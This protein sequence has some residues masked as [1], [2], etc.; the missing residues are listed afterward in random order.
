[1]GDAQPVPSEERLGQLS[2]LI[3]LI[4]RAHALHPARHA[5][6]VTKARAGKP[7]PAAEVLANNFAV[8][9]NTQRRAASHLATTMSGELGDVR[10]ASANCSASQPTT[11]LKRY[12]TCRPNPA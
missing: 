1:M 9:T 4:C 10:F 2:V 5:V 11:S 3:E 8:L 7:Y 6:G 12:L